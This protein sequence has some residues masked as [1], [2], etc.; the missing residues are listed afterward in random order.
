ML[1]FTPATLCYASSVTLCF[2]C[3]VGL[4]RY[5]MSPTLH[6]DSHATSFLLWYVIP[7]MLCHASYDTS[8]LPCYVMTPLLHPVCSTTLC[9]L[10][11]H[12]S[13]KVLLQLA[14]T[15]YSLISSPLLYFFLS[16]PSPS[17]L[18]CLL[19]HLSLLS[20]LPPPILFSPHFLLLCTSSTI[21]CTV[22]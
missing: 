4:L 8:F 7:P 17:V 1:H 19:S 5:V 15:N 10:Y 12:T 20:L 18:L 6:H 22:L 2:L 21:E 9:H 14:I 13:Y 16:S 3:Y 11:C